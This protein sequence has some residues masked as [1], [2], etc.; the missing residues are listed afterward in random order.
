[1]KKRGAFRRARAAGAV[2]GKSAALTASGAIPDAADAASPAWGCDG[3]NGKRLNMICI[4][5]NIPATSG[6]EK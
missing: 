1:M 6:P 4:N 2:C 3:Q 5:L